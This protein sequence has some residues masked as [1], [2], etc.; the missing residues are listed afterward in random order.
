MS[1]SSVIP[2]RKGCLTNDELIE[3]R[4]WRGLT[5][6]MSW[7]SIARNLGRRSPDV[8]TAFEAASREAPRS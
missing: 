6:P 5:P 7:D 3:V 8:R 4:R 1:R 2:S